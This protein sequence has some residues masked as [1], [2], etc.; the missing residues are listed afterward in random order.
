M[1][2]QL[3]PPD[4]PWHALTAEEAMAALAASEHGLASTAAGQRLEKFGPNELDIKPEVSSITVFLRQ[5]KSPLIYIL[6]VAAFIALMLEKHLDVTVILGLVLLNAV[7]GYFQ[8]R[9]AQ[10]ALTALRRMTSPQA[11]V[12]RQGEPYELPASQVVPGD[13]LLLAVG[14]LVAADGRLLRT[15]DLEVDEA[16]LTGESL[17]VLKTTQPLTTPEL[18]LGD[19]TNMVYMNTVITRGKGR[20]VVV[21]T[22]LASEVGRI[23]GRVAQAEIRPPLEGR[24]RQFSWQL[25]FLVIGIMAA[26]L[27]LGLIRQIPFLEMF[28]LALSLAVSAI[29]EGLPIVLTVLL[30]IGVWR[31]SKHNAL[32]RHLPAVEGLG[33]ATVICTDKTGTLTQNRMIVRRIF[34]PGRSYAVTGNGYE[35]FGAITTSEARAPI[36]WQADSALWQLLTASLLCN[37]AELVEQDSIWRVRGD[38]T[39]GALLALAAKAGLDLYWE[40]LA[41]ITYTSE[42]RWMATLHRSGSGQLVVFAKG[43]LE[44]LLPMAKMVQEPNGQLRPL[45]PATSAEIEQVGNAMASATLRVLAFCYLPEAKE[46][47]HLE[48]THLAGELVFLG[49]VGMLDPP[50]SEAIMAINQCHE[51]GIRVVMITGDHLIT[52]QAIA[53]EMGII[54]DEVAQEAING[55]E[56]SEMTDAELLQ[57]CERTVIYAR[58]DPEHKLRI[59]KALQTSGHIVAVTGD[60]VNDAPALSQADIGVAMGTGT[61]VAKSAADLVIT[62]D[63]FATIVAA[64]REGRLIVQNLRKVMTY[65]FS[66]NAGEI[67]TVSLATLLGLPLPLVAVQILWINLITD[68]AFD[69]TLALETAQT[70]LMHI[71]PRSPRAPLIDR[72]ILHSV[73]LAAPLMAIGTLFIFQQALWTDD[74]LEKARTMAFSTLVFFQWLAAFSFRSFDRPIYQLPPNHWMWYGLA[75]AIILH[76]AVIYLPPMQALFHTV[77]LSS[78]ELLKALLVASTVLLFNEGRK[79]FSKIRALHLP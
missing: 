66:T 35:P 72:Q 74:S 76:L 46:A 50:R 19:R 26:L 28:M 77:S 37:D 47:D 59:V 65:L 23:A 15:D 8:E 6:L 78:T 71:P 40:R 16:I 11:T 34:L 20:A 24:I 73:L 51:A 68:G 62:D 30:A 39:E 57:R 33:S 7:I 17:P 64:I 52:A 49:L 41:E 44:R 4:G 56:L 27:T 1:H 10:A 53:K 48:L 61:E 2:D 42:R 75:A 29:P 45:D 25:A 13:I 21:A 3:A 54:S 12:L 43:A 36:A 70:D 63:N 69:K 58:V 22:G 32:V 31:M 18:P 79:Y 14:D 60:G 5:F 38:P 55:N 9:K 67:V